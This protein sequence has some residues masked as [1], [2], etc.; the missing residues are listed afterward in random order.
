MRCSVESCFDVHMECCNES[1]RVRKKL[2]FRR[3]NCL[4]WCYLSGINH[5]NIVIAIHRAAHDCGLFSSILVFP[6][7][8]HHKIYIFGND[9]LYRLLNVT[10]YRMRKSIQQFT[11][12]QKVSQ[13]LIACKFRIF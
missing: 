12:L 10:N 9:F 4:N 8:Y 7:V 3:Y 5:I 6:M 1:L 2:L 13:K 11:I